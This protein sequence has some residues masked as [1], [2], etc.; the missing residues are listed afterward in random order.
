VLAGGRSVSGSILPLSNSTHILGVSAGCAL[1]V[2]MDYLI[3]A[4]KFIEHARKAHC[5]E[6][7]KTD[8]EMAEWFLS[9]ALEE[10]DGKPAKSTSS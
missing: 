5:Q 10:R 1:E 4:K 8:L 2:P 9:K 3:E 6:V 7:I